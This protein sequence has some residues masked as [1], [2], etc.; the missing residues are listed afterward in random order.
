MLRLCSQIGTFYEVLRL[1]TTLVEVSK[2]NHYFFLRY[3]F[4]DF[5][6]Y[7]KLILLIPQ[8]IINPYIHTLSVI[9]LH[10]PVQ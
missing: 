3:I 10:S 1:Y 7:H 8:T 5:Y 2:S 6:N 4:I 9:R